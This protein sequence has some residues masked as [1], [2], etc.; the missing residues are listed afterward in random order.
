[1]IRKS[2]CVLLTCFNRCNKTINCVTTLTS[3]N[4][5]IQFEFVIVDDK[6]SDG[7]VECLR[8]LTDYNIHILEG[9]GN[10]YYSGG[11]R[12]AIA[13]AKETISDAEY[14]LLVNDDVSFY[15]KSI[16]EILTYCNGNI[17]VGMTDDGNNKI[18]YGGVISCN[19]F[20]P[21]LR[22]TAPEHGKVLHADTFNANCVLIPARVFANLDNID[23]HYVHGFGD[24]DYGFEAR[25]KG[26]DII[27]P[28]IFVGMC[29]RN[30]NTNTWHDTNLSLKKRISLKEKP[31]GSPTK[32]WFYFTRK[33]Y[34]IASAIFV[35]V[36]QY[37]KLFLGK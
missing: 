5:D 22:V 16:Q 36:Y 11:M 15:E 31:T 34:G 24:Y 25:R 17:V 6:S 2:V 14:Y 7:T 18:T 1:M 4:P 8:R 30:S 19:K 20:R 26:I 13:Y 28:D 27:V 32:M 23:S 29:K 12:K 10:L 35:V 37:V 33:N 21:S 3:S 9:T